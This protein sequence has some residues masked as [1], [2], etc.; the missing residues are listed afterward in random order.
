MGDAVDFVVDLADAT[1]DECMSVLKGLV[2]LGD[3]A[4]EQVIQ[5]LGLPWPEARCCLRSFDV[6]ERRIVRHL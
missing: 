2:S 5:F 1:L 4:V 6:A 3:E